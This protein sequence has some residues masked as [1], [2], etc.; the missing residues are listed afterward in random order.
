ESSSFTLVNNGTIQGGDGGITDVPDESNGGAGVAAISD[1]S[2]NIVHAGLIAGG[3]ADDANGKR[4]PAVAL[5]G[6]DNTV[7]LKSG[8]AFKG[9]VISGLEDP[10]ED[11]GNIDLAGGNTL[12]LGGDKDSAFDLS[13]I[14]G[15]TTINEDDIESEGDA[16]TYY[17]FDD[18]K[19]TGKSTWTLTGET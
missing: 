10:D 12:V 7:T 5:L 1:G 11:T 13:S 18:Y 9:N 16:T 8:Y 3:G 14:D 17:G 6:S 2:T 19:K 4:A 15:A